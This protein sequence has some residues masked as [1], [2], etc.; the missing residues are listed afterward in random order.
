VAECPDACNIRLGHLEED[1][2]AMEQCMATFKR[3]LSVRV[4]SHTMI[5][6]GVLAVGILAGLLGSLW[7]D[8]TGLHGKVDLIREDQVKVITTLKIHVEDTNN[9]GNSHG[10]P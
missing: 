4:K 1:M 5:A 8:M 3:D 2:K 7:N 9:G 6:I 10:R